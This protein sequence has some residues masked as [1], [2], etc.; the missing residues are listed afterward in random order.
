MITKLSSGRILSIDAFRGI[1]ILVMIFVNS[2]AGVDGI[3]SWMQHAHANEDRMTFVDVVFPAFLFIVGMSIPFA[4]NSRLTK[5]DSFW[6]LQKHI[7]WRT[8]GL[9][10]LGVF[11]VNTDGLNANATGTSKAVWALLFYGSVI[12]VWNV[13]TFQQRWISWVLKGI[14][15]VILIVLALIYRGGEDGTHYLSP[16]WWGILGLIGWAYVYA[17]MIYQF[18][19]G[20]PGAIFLMIAA[21]IGF[22]ILCQQPFMENGAFSW[23]TTQAGNAAHTSI[24]LCGMLLT[25]FYF[26]EDLGLTGSRLVSRVVGFFALLV[27]A[28]SLLRPAYKLSKINA[29][30]SWCLYCSAICVAVFSLLYFLIDVKHLSRWT[31]FFKPAGSNPLLTYILPDI[32][33]FGMIALSLNLPA[34]LGQGLP[35]IIWCACFAVAMLF[36]VKGLNKLHIRLQL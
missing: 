8:L 5:G 26:D 18:F 23:L 19:K 3:P 14:G 10:V 22:Y 25:L 13:Y 28:G 35:G 2:V 36:L 34:V 12:L 21:C 7:L 32:V 17:C 1:T 4:I 9:L 24:V 27:V 31:S 20:V 30:P 15:A 11:M 16:Q 29:T 6:Q 33:Y